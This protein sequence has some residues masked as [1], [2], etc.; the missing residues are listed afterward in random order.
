MHHHGGALGDGGPEEEE[1]ETLH[2]HSCFMGG[3]GPGSF[4]T[5]NHR[6]RTQ[7]EQVTVFL[8]DSVIF[9]LNFLKYKSC[10]TCWLQLGGIQ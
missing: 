6:E 9:I 4:S 2:Q 10:I 5:V 7:N 8:G 1:E 3:E